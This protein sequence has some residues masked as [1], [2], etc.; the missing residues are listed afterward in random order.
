MDIFKGLK[1]GILVKIK[2]TRPD[3]TLFDNIYETK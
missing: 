1:L 3:K 2:Y